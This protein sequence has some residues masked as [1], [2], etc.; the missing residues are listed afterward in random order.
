[1]VVQNLTLLVVL[2]CALAFGLGVAG[3]FRKSLALLVSAGMLAMT[4]AG[5]ALT[6]LAFA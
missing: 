4:V 1:M 3:V 6:S 5:F 2:V